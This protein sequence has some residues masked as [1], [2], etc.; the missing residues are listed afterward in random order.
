MLLKLLSKSSLGSVRR[1]RWARC[2]KMLLLLLV[3]SGNWDESRVK[4]PSLEGKRLQKLLPL[5]R[6]LL[7]AGR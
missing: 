7:A 1:S 6:Q 5:L 4:A 2:E 3:R